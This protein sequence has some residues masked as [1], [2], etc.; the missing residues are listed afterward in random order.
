MLLKRIKSSGLPVYERTLR[1]GA[2]NQANIPVYA[3]THNGLFRNARLPSWG[4]GLTDDLA[5][6]S[7]LME[8][9]E[10]F[11]ASDSAVR[12]KELV[13][14][15]FHGIKNLGA[16]SRW[17]FVPCNLQRKLYSKREI[18]SQ[19]RPWVRCYSLSSK[20]ETFI[21][22][23]LVFLNPRLCRD[24]FSNSMGLATGNNIEEAILHAL[25]EIIE[26]H[27]E[28][29][30]SWNKVKV[31]TIDVES[32]KN[33]QLSDLIVR[34]VRDE[35]LEV[36]LNYFTGSFKIPAIRIF[37]YPRTP[38]YLG[39]FSFYTALGVHPDKNVAL[40]RAITELMQVRAAT[41]FLLRH[42]HP[43]I[44]ML[45]HMPQDIHSFFDDV[46]DSGKRIPFRAIESYNQADL[47]EDIKF[48]IKLLHSKGCEII[49]KDLTH[50]QIGIPAV[51]V[52][53][54]GLQPGILGV[55]IVNL[56]DRAVRISRH[57]HYFR[58][59]T[60]NIKKIKLVGH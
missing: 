51:R 44:N 10:R 23:N 1:I 29:V 30:V 14:S 20:K 27:L 45:N 53:V 11:T 26:C 28:D 46:I 55:G 5:L 7:G 60:R 37:A 3:V 19:K 16:I 50:P 12:K 13:Y 25:C 33:R 58:Y 47:L 39:N 38:P 17:D 22:A 59:L 35:G 6:V 31:S 8:R 2:L 4:K 48:I 57:L 9:V 21:P 56:H 42:N 40:A 36:K 32:I 43:T 54:T 18:D 34:I 49:A 52:L 15:D 41:M 24:D